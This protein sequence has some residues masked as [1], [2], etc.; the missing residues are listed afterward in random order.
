MD[1][2]SLDAARAVK[3]KVAAMLSGRAEVTGIGITRVNDGFGVKVNLTRAPEFDLG[4]PSVVE[5]VPVIVEVVGQIRK[6]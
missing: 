1:G 4:I 2:V 5:G 3:T 6:Q